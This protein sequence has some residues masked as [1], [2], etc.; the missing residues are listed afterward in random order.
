MVDRFPMKLLAK[1]VSFFQAISTFGKRYLVYKSFI[2]LAGFPA[3]TELEG[4]FLF[5]NDIAPTTVFSPIV[6]P[7]RI[8]VFAPTHTFFSSIIGE[9]LASMIEV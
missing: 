4:K 9:L 7:F 3:Q 1:V 5:T 2:F 8:V 6:I